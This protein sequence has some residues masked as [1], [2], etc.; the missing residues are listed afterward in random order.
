MRQ[1]KWKLVRYGKSPWALYDMEADRTELTDLSAKLPD[2]AK[3]MAA[4][5][6]AWAKRCG[7]VLPSG[8]KKKKT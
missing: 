7:V 4:L 6:N 1:G 5:W 8:K 3:A 2:R